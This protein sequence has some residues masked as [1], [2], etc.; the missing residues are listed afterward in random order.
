MRKFSDCSGASLW[1]K[2]CYDPKNQGGIACCLVNI[3]PDGCLNDKRRLP[4]LTVLGI[5]LWT[6]ILLCSAE[7]AEEKGGV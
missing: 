5:P 6:S 1:S 7:Q 3:E 2:K 4:H